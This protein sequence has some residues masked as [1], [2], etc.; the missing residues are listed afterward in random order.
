VT[1]DNSEVKTRSYQK[2]IISSRLPSQIELL[3]G[4]YGGNRNYK[5]EEIQQTYIVF[6]K[7]YGNKTYKFISSPHHRQTL[8]SSAI[9][10][11]KAALTCMLT[12]QIP[13]IIILT[14]TK[15]EKTTYDK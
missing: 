8:L 1:L 2:E 7:R 13:T 11:S 4:L 5:T 12:K 3:D 10:T 9:L 14:F 15:R 6:Y